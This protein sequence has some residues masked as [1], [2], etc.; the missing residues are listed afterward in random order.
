M[1]TNDDE[2]MSVELIRP[3]ASRHILLEERGDG[4]R[5]MRQLNSLGSQH[6]VSF[7]LDKRTDQM[8]RFR[9]H[10]SIDTDRGGGGGLR[11]GNQPV[12]PVFIPRAGI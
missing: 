5:I 2:T 11:G 7:D 12:S 9:P 4:W 3:L 8:G 10:G 1:E 6:C